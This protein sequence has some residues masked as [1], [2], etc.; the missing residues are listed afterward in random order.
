MWVYFFIDADEIVPN[1]FLKKLKNIILNDCLKIDA[2]QIPL[3]F[4]YHGRDIKSFGLP[5]KVTN[6]V[7]NYFEI[8][9]DNAG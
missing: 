4:S 2:Y 8:L 7:G 1:N 6:G 3:L 5:S 9:E